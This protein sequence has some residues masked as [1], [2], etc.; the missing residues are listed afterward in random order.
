M[1][2]S[3][4]LSQ[5]DLEKE[6][7]EFLDRTPTLVLSTSAADR[8]TARM[9][10]V[11][12]VGLAVFFQASTESTKFEQMQQNPHV[13]LC[14]GNL[15][16]EGLA[17]LHGHPLAPE[18]AFFASAYCARHPGSFKAYSGLNHNRV[19]EVQLTR[20][21]FWKYDAEG[22]PLRDFWDIS[23]GKAWREYYPTT[24]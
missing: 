12:H 7:L 5:T 17:V 8:V 3:I 15:Q 21:T 9:M 20:A 10:S 4:P 16:L 22:K 2:D 19:I 14:A 23:A 13:A 18:N 24:E 6:V 1:P 11:I